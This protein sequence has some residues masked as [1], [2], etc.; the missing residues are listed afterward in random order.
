[1]KII[2][3]IGHPAHVH[4]FRNFIKIM[5]ER[6]HAFL[7]IAKNRNVTF[8]LLKHYNIPFLSRKDYPKSLIGK[9]IRIPFTDLFILLHAIKFKADILLGFS[10][11]H[12]AH[13]GFFLNRPRIVID[14]TEHAKFAHHSYKSFASDILTPEC[15]NKE[16]GKK[17]IRF[18]G[19]MELCYLHSKYFIVDKTIR[20]E[21]GISENE[22]F[23]I[24][25][26]VSW[27]ASHDFGQ[28]GVTQAFKEK[29]VK[30]LSTK[31]KVLISSESNLPSSLEKYSFN[32]PPEKMH[33]AL[34]EC[35][36]FIGE[37]A[38]MASECACLG[39]PA[40][41]I[42]PLEVGYCTEEENKY[43]LIYGFRNSNGVIEK[44]IELLETSDIS[45]KWKIRCEK[46]ISEKI[47]V[48]AFFVWFIENYPSSK[49][50]MH[51]DQY[52]VNKFINK[53]T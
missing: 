24:L 45:L 38:T 34:A 32:L 14:D 7:I 8:N 25:R 31:C 39:T 15:F 2:I 18:N 4:Y 13:A 19:Y 33:H 29:L 44:S 40:I 9:L 16:F 41:Y 27:K 49:K 43:N 53:I 11:T 17:Q 21:I 46:M 36:L 6:G 30:E 52:Y 37:G 23:V 5:E 35:D 28:R 42:N 20:Q 47:D 48:T 22:K 10:G 51:Q 12:I 1:M 50:I 3:D 26:F